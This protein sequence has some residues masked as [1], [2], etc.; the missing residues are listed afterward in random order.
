MKTHK[1]KIS[2]ISECYEDYGTDI[3]LLKF[4]SAMV[5]TSCIKRYKNNMHKTASLPPSAR[6]LLDYLIQVMNADNE[7]QNSA[8]LR[9]SYISFMKKSCSMDCKEETINKGFQLLKANDLLISFKNKRGL[10]TVNPLYFYCGT[11][12]KRKK[13][14]K[15]LLNLTSEKQ[16]ELTN[17]K[18]ALKI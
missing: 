16:Y 9:Q 2:Y 3:K 12:A 15:R 8:L 14:I 17:L 1:T 4:K 11:E 6:N 7:I 18:S 10:Y 13:L 5:M